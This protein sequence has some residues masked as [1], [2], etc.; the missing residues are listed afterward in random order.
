[1]RTLLEITNDFKKAFGS[2]TGTDADD[3]GMIRQGMKDALAHTQAR[4]YRDPEVL[5]MLL[6]T[7]TAGAKPADALGALSVTLAALVRTYA[8]DADH[9]QEGCKIVQDALAEHLRLAADGLR[10]P[11]SLTK[12]PK[13]RSVAEITDALRTAIGTLPKEPEDDICRITSIFGTI[14]K[15]YLLA[16]DNPEVVVAKVLLEV[17]RDYP[18]EVVILSTIRL[19]AA[20]LGAASGNAKDFVSM[21]GHCIE[22]LDAMLDEIGSLIKAKQE[23]NRSRK[24]V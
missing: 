3:L 18:V 15:P 5:A 6:G 12:Q 4:I 22:A 11:S 20:Q 23:T 7:C 24:D 2:T 14:M 9:F 17:I 21:R 10:P 8:N 19:L 16:A 1:M 13:I